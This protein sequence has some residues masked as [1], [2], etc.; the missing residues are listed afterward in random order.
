MCWVC[1]V[2]ENKLIAFGSHAKR[3]T[4]QSMQGRVVQWKSFA[5]STHKSPHVLH[6]SVKNFSKS[7]TNR[8]RIYKFTPTQKVL[9]QIWKYPKT[10]SVCRWKGR[11]Y[12]SLTW[13]TRYIPW[14]PGFPYRPHVPTWSFLEIYRPPKE[15]DHHLYEWV[16]QVSVAPTGQRSD[17]ECLP[18]RPRRVSVLPLSSLHFDNY[19]CLFLFL[20]K[21]RN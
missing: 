2:Y 3:Y 7:K 9:V 1:G 6:G 4:R 11:I 5:H 18:T 13:M 15:V 14:L 19:N 10:V 17:H 20:W 16:P 12:I 8:S 21:W